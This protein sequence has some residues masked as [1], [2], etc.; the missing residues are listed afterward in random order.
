MAWREVRTRDLI[1]EARAASA[2]MTRAD[3][4][5]L[6]EFGVPAAA[7]EIFQL[8]GIARISRIVDIGLYEPDPS[9][10]LAF[11][12]PALVESPTTPESQSPG[13]FALGNI[14][15]LVAWDPQA[16]RDWALRA[17]QAEWLGCVPSQYLDPEPVPVWRTVLNWFRAGCTGLVV[18]S[19][20]PAEI[21]RLLMGFP[22]GILG[23]DEVH[24][25]ELRRTLERPWPVPPISVGPPPASA[26]EVALATE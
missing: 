25:A 16:P 14:V 10:A 2:A 17:L 8:V 20:E 11:I 15:D 12:T 9:G 22:G 5:E 3:V 26:G 13:A 7:V 6:E 21:Y 23:E 24:C 19:R 4:A 1:A 18:L